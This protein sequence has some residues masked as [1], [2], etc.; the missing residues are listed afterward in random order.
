MSEDVYNEIMLEI[1]ASCETCPI[2]DRCSEDTCP[3]WSIEQ[4]CEKSIITSDK[5]RGTYQCF[6][7]GCNTVSWCSDFSFE[8]YGLEGEGV[9]NVCHCSNCGADIEYYVPIG[10]DND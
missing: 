9:I 6:H 5:P 4:V 1:S 10:V 3:L 7:C 2:K 8:D